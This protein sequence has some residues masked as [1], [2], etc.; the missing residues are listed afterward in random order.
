MANISAFLNYFKSIG[1][2]PP[3]PAC[4]FYVKKN[5]KRIAQVPHAIRH[6]MPRHQKRGFHTK[7]S[8]LRYTKKIFEMSLRI[9]QNF[10]LGKPNPPL[11]QNGVREFHK[12]A[13]CG[14]R[15]SGFFLHKNDRGMTPC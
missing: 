8:L 10:G 7:S 5:H 2:K 4:R 6:A 13:S 9:T 15:F 12:S 11:P 14:R 3:T 1:R